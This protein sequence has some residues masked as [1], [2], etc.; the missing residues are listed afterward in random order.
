MALERKSTR[1]IA[2]P[3]AQ[4]DLTNR[5]DRYLRVGMSTL[6]NQGFG[7]N[8][9]SRSNS[10]PGFYQLMVCGYRIR[11]LAKT[12]P[13]DIVAKMRSQNRNEKRR[14]GAGHPAIT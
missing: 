14:K 4:V 3:G 9:A 2:D 1:I 7:R 10:W 6:S 5:P 11:L 12:Y 8:V 13:Q